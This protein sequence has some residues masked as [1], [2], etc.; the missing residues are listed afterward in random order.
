[1][2]QLKRTHLTYKN[3]NITILSDIDASPAREELIKNYGLLER[4]SAKNPL[5]LSSYEPLPADDDAP[6]IAK[7]MLS[8]AQKTGVGPMAAVAGAF[9]DLL[10]GFLLE[11]GASEVIVENGGDIFLQLTEPRTVGIYA[12]PS[13]LSDRLAFNVKPE[14]TPIGIC[15][16]SN[17][18]GPSISLGRSDATTVVADSSAIA[19]AAA[20]AIG[21]AV[22]G[23]DG[24]KEAIEIAKS[25]ECV[26][27]MLVIRG[28]EMGA[29]G[30][31][32]PLI[33]TSNT[34]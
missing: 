30:K 7:N 22:K 31:L 28:E 8:A 3:S 32:P 15:T 19:D 17:S 5:F 20:S 25:I 14:E 16:S 6:E 12:G 2:N 13:K 4:Y 27:G 9:S 29:W 26:R 24:M 21:N 23:A 10:G 33:K 18:V 1:M 34:K 11:I